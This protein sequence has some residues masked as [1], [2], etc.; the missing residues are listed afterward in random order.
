MDDDL[1]RELDELA[2]RPERSRDFYLRAALPEMLPVLCE[3]Y[4]A[5]DVET[6]RNELHTFNELTKQ[7]ED[8]PHNDWP[9]HDMPRPY[10]HFGQ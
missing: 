7:L 9:Q 6:R 3:R 10:T 8:D 1:V 5:H 4:W 2:R